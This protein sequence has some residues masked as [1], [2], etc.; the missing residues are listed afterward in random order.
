MFRGRQMIPWTMLKRIGVYLFFLGLGI[1]FLSELL[2]T[3]R[4]LGTILF[5]GGW[6]LAIVGAVANGVAVVKERFFSD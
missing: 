6:M 3:D 4:N 2:V 1:W 5:F